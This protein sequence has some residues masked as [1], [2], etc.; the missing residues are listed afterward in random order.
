[1]KKTH[2]EYCE[3]VS[4]VNVKGEWVPLESVE[5]VDISED[6]QGYDVVTFVHEGEERQSRVAIMPK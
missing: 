2:D 5:F 1:M 6:M 3:M 4:H